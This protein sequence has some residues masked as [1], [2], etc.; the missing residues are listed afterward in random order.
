MKQVRKIYDKVFKE[1]AV[2]L[3]RERTKWFLKNRWK[4]KYLNTLKF[5][6]TE[7][8]DM[9]LWIIQLLKNLTIKLI[10]KM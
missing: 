8:G 5:G 1:K 10:A 2:P 7:K 9:L 3:S 4:W 6:T